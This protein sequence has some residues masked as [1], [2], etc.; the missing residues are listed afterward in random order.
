[1]LAAGWMD[2]KDMFVLT[3]CQTYAVA[4]E[5]ERVRSNSKGARLFASTTKWCNIAA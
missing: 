1:M 5:A 3:S 2:K 4:P